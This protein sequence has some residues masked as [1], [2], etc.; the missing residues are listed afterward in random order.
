MLASTWRMC[1]H[2]QYTELNKFKHMAPYISGWQHRL[3]YSL[4]WFWVDL[5]QLS[6]RYCTSNTRRK[7]P[8]PAYSVQVHDQIVVHHQIS[9]GR[10]SGNAPTLLLGAMPSRALCRRSLSEVAALCRS[11]A[12]TSCSAASSCAKITSR[13]PCMMSSS[14]LATPSCNRPTLL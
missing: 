11:C 1:S 6:M 4:W 2:N 10:H 14:W 13:D 8:A 12:S 9:K 7:H 3:G 5:Q